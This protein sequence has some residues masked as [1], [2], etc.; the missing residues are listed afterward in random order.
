MLTDHDIAKKQLFS[1]L[2]HPIAKFIF[3]PKNLLIF[4]FRRYDISNCLFQAAYEKILEE[5]K[6]TPYFHW[7]N[8]PFDEFCRGRTLKCMNE[9]LERIGQFNVVEGKP[10]LAACEDQKNSVS[11]TTSR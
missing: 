7:G 6:C 1:N 9:I 8:L 3:R 11:I 4:A 2:A 5:C 10:C